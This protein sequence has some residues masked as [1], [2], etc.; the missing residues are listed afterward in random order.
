MSL[1]F[2]TRTLRDVG[3]KNSTSVGRTGKEALGPRNTQLKKTDDDFVN[4]FNKLPLNFQKNMREMA[5]EEI[6]AILPTRE[7]R[8][9]CRALGDA[10]HLPNLPNTRQNNTKGE[11]YCSNLPYRLLDRARSRVLLDAFNKEV[12]Y[13]SKVQTNI[14][15]ENRKI[16]VYHVYQNNE[17]TGEL[18]SIGG[19]DIEPNKAALFEIC[20]CDIQREYE[21]IQRKIEDKEN[22]IFQNSNT[23]LVEDAEK[24]RMEQLKIL[25]KFYKV[26]IPN[27]A[28]VDEEGDFFWQLSFDVSCEA[29]NIRVVE[30]LY[31]QLI[32]NAMKHQV[33]DLVEVGEST[34]GR[35][36]LHVNS[37][38]FD[39]AIMWATGAGFKKAKKLVPF[40]AKR[41]ILSWDWNKL[42]NN[43][44]GYNYN[45]HGTEDL[46]K[47]IF[48][49]LKVLGNFPDDECVEIFKILLKN[50]MAT[51]DE[52][53][54]S[55]HKKHLI[56]SYI[57]FWAVEIFK[58]DYLAPIVVENKQ[59]N[60]F[61]GNNH[62][63]MS[64]KEIKFAH[65]YMQRISPSE[66]REYI[67]FG[68]SDEEEDEEE[69]EF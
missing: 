50:L 2:D 37:Y 22:K 30:F 13:L 24:L 40:F 36:L 25:Q 43:K 33:V 39:S 48:K 31:E 38:L 9:Y 62:P 23:S 19:S 61:D 45:K 52:T 16:P 41:V 12:N 59:Q 3:A 27:L 69:D 28:K 1:V 8:A 7:R 56:L 20:V 53:E 14:I 35:P 17:Y 66:Y 54:L 21:E 60:A 42:S 44:G 64:E 57:Q 15:V 67:F 18:F 63:N 34:G 49:I 5:H 51:N 47:F 26:K 68:N 11:T 29:G 6:L 32:E 10:S 4:L 46:Y 58:L 65:Y 55:K